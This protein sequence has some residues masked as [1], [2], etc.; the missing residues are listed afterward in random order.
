MI[1]QEKIAKEFLEFQRVEG[2]A[3]IYEGADIFRWSLNESKNNFLISKLELAR[4]TNSAWAKKSGM[5][6]DISVY[7]LTKIN[8]FFLSNNLAHIKNTKKI[9]YPVI[10]LDQNYLSNGNNEYAKNISKFNL[11]LIAVNGFHGLINNNRKFYWNSLKN[12]FEPTYYDSDLSV[13]ELNLKEINYNIYNFPNIN[14]VNELVDELIIDLENIN[15]S[16]FYENIKNLDHNLTVSKILKNKE[17]IINNL[18]KIKNNYKQL[19]ENT[20]SPERKNDILNEALISYASY[21]K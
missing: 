11:M 2:K 4:Q 12:T 7:A 17:I 21:G 18:K 5:H 10:N 9:N 3:P 19:S 20:S 15:Y 1:F 6:K 8:Q 16:L 14:E 13:A